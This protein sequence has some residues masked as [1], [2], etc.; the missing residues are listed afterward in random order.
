VAVDP[1]GVVQGQLLIGTAGDDDGRFVTFAD[2]K[3]IF[4]GITGSTSGPNRNNIY[5][6]ALNPEDLSI[7][8]SKVYGGDSATVVNGLNVD[9]TD[10]NLVVAG[11]SNKFGNGEQGLLFKVNSTDGSIVWAKSWG[12]T[13]NEFLQG[14]AILGDGSSLITG[15]G[16]F[17]STPSDI[18]VAHS[19]ANGDFCDFSSSISIR[20]SDYTP[21]VAGPS[22]AEQRDSVVEFPVQGPLQMTNSTHS[23]T[24]LAQCTS[25]SIQQ[26]DIS[27]NITLFPNP[28][29][30]RLLIR[31][32]APWMTNMKVS[33]YNMLGAEVKTT[34]IAPNTKEFVLDISGNAAGMYLITF[35]DGNT[36]KAAKV[37]L[38]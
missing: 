7:A 13:G 14:S 32:D 26:K 38:K 21:T 4:S 27:K 16:S 23:V 24:V 30:G 20:V 28:T 8:W 2:N 17:G 36:T 34:T 18:F 19:D 37:M 31:A 35:N 25:T 29:D 10:G 12:T 9:Q 5:I 22:L 3:L 33:V 15:F 11:Q 1:S 6:T